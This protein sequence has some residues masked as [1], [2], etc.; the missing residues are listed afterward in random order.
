M[1]ISHEAAIRQSP[2]H[3]A[4]STRE[5]PRAS[6]P[7]FAAGVLSTSMARLRMGIVSRDRSPHIAHAGVGDVML[8]E[9]VRLPH[10]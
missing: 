8:V 5:A 6:R 9:S 10:R 2:A 3:L 1:S 7:T 4:R